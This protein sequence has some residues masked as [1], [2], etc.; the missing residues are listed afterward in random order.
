LAIANWL[1]RLRHREC[2]LRRFYSEREID[3]YIRHIPQ[4]LGC[5][6]GHHGSPGRI[7]AVKEHLLKERGVR[8]R[9]ALEVITQRGLPPLT[10]HQPPT[11]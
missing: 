5:P 8:V 9:D 10:T 2:I 1:Q 3:L 6:A 11:V 7:S 4:T